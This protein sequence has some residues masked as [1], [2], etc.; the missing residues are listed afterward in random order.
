MMTDESARDESGRWRMS[1]AEL[2]RLAHRA[3]DAEVRDLA[4]AELEK[5]R[6]ERQS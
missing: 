1:D 5:R 3:L 2:W 4:R 6:Q